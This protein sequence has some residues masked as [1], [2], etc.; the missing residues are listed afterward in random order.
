L[1]ALESTAKTL[2]SGMESV[3]NT[4]KAQGYQHHKQLLKGQTHLA[5][6]RKI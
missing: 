2:L 3:K 1:P 5:E 6:F 4:I